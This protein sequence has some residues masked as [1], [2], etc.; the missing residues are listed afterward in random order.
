VDT[1]VTAS[2]EARKAD[3]ADLRELFQQKLDGLK[4]LLLSE[5]TANT[6]VIRRARQ[7]VHRARHDEQNPGGRGAQVRRDLD[8]CRLCRL[9]KAIVKSDVNAEKWRENANEWRAAMMDRRHGSSPAP[10]WTRSSRTFVPI[11]SD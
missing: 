8:E 2:V 9:E 3:V 10:K 11:S 6:K 1:R 5:L 4:D 7:A